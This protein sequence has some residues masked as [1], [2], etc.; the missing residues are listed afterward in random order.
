MHRILQ[1]PLCGGT[2]LIFELSCK[3]H[4]TSGETFDILH[5]TSCDVRLTNPQPDPDELAKYYQ[6]NSYVSHSDKPGTMFDAAYHSVRSFAL[7]WKYRLVTGHT[8]SKP[9]SIL[10]FGSGTGDFLQVCRAKGMKVAG[11]E[12][13]EKARAISS[14]RHGITP[15]PALQVSTS[16]VDVITAW[17]VLEHVPNVTDTLVTLRNALTENGT[18]F[19]AVPNP[20]SADAKQYREYWAG[21]DVPRHLWHFSSKSMIGLLEQTGLTCIHIEPMKLDAYYVSLLS[22]KYMKGAMTPMTIASSI[23]NGFLSNMKGSKNKNH[24]SL[25]YIA[26]KK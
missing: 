9:V 13:S 7:Q 10:D 1:C 6:S 11:V 22:E 26:R 25:I 2:E 18:M 19:I 4:T 20:I 24:S 3:D 16:A 21:Y 14:A 15:A 17:H 5:C 23:K 12:P 8:I